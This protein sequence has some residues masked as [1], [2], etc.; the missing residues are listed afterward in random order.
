MTDMTA[1][2]V[3]IKLLQNSLL[4]SS[5]IIQPIFLSVRHNYS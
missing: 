5:T 4:P 3:L 1:K 2:F